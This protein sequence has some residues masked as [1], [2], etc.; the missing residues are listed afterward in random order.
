MMS[1]ISCLSSM[2]QLIL[3]LLP[4]PRSIMMCLFLQGAAHAHQTLPG[5]PLARPTT[6]LSLG[7]PPPTDLPQENPRSPPASACGTPSSQTVLC[8]AT[9]LCELATRTV[10][11]RHA[12]HRP[13]GPPSLTGLHT[14]LHTWSRHDTAARRLGWRQQQ[15][16]TRHMCQCPRAVS[17]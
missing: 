12:L 5:S 2:A 17:F 3:L 11:P 6:G 8:A 9:R 15:G 4:V 7:D 16:D 13:P 1:I 14:G 10:K